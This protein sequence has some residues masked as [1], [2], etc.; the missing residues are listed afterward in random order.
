MVQLVHCKLRMFSLFLCMLPV[1][2]WLPFLPPDWLPVEKQVGKQALGR[3]QLL[4]AFQ[5]RMVWVRERE[6][7]ELSAKTK[8]LFTLLNL[9]SIFERAQLKSRQQS[10]YN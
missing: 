10:R 6:R 5:Q 2:C 1:F 4:Y 7:W 9:Y 3:L 8:S